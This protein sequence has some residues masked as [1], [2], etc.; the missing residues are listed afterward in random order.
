MLLRAGAWPAAALLLAL[1]ASAAAEELAVIVHPTRTTALDAS[2]IAQI[3]LKQRRRWPEGSTIVP[4]NR[5]PDSAERK[6]FASAV[7]GQT[8]Q[9]LAVYWNRRYFHGVQPPATLASEEAV[10]R[11]VAR[12]PRAIGYVRVSALDASVR[13]ALRLPEPSP[14]P[15]D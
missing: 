8:P 13:V 2:E 11:F 12:E 6:Q 9:Q 4:V 10:K 7:L 5:E 3:Y 1:A 15:R 14:P